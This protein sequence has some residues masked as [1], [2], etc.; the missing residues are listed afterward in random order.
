[1]RVV[2]SAGRNRCFL[3]FPDFQLLEENSRERDLHGT[4]VS[5]VDI[6]TLSSDGDQNFTFLA[7][8]EL[9]S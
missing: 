8:K 3:L 2:S 5:L 4:V 6:K 9:M 1:M 7:I